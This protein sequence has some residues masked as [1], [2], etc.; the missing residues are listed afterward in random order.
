MKIK[1]AYGQISEIFGE[2]FFDLDIFLR[3]LDFETLAD[4][5]I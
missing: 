2:K 5:F 4:N 3:S 1:Y